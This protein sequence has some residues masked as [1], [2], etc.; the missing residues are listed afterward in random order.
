MFTSPELSPGDDG[1]KSEVI[2]VRT[3]YGAKETNGLEAG[4]QEA[5]LDAIREG[6]SQKVYWSDPDLKKI[7]RLR[8]L[9]DP[10]FPFWD[11]SY[12]YGELKDGTAVR[13]SLPFHQLRKGRV[14]ADIIEAA[15]ADGV[16]AKGLGIFEV[17]STLL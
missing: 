4:E 3:R 11:V 1:R 6:G 17:I 8:L 15:K 7:T 14:N 9:S 13:V 10:G 16:Y 5:W 2:D 12:C